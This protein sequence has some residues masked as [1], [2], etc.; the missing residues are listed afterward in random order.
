[1]KTW[2]WLLILLGFAC[3][4]CAH[5][6]VKPVCSAHKPVAVIEVREADGVA[7]ENKKWKRGKGLWMVRTSG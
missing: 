6:P 1:M 5:A 4:G 7:V 2:K 3:V